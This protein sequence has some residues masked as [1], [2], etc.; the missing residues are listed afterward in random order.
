MSPAQDVQH[1]SKPLPHR[2]SLSSASSATGSLAPSRQSHSR[3]NSHSVL[4]GPANANRVTRRKSMTNPAANAAAVAAAL[5]EAGDRAMPLPIAVSSRRN[6]MSKGSRSALA[7]SLPSPP[8]SLPSHKFST[9]DGSGVPQDSAIDDD[10][11][12][13][14]ADEGE[15]DLQQARVRRASDGQ[16]F[17]KEGGRKSSRPDLRCD[18]CGKGYKHSSCLTKH[19][20]V[21]AFISHSFPRRV[22]LSQSRQ[23]WAIS[24]PA[25]GRVPS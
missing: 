20:F 3:N 24:G 10:L 18:K 5:Q 6:T 1:A 17:A 9:A 13:V 12:D 19:L 15:T 16:P 2:F 21:P 8:A 14:S 22:L 23:A 25:C 4:V 7:G 11:N